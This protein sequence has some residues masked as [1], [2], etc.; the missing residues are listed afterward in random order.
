MATTSR[1][2]LREWFA[3]KAK[4]SAGQF[5][6]LFDS[7]WHKSDDAL[8]ISNISELANV[9]AGKVSSEQLEAIADKLGDLEALDTQNTSNLVA[10]INEVLANAGTSTYKRSSP[11]TRQVGGI[12]IGDV[13]TGKALDEL[14]EKML[15]PYTAPTL[16]N[17]TLTGQSAYNALNI[18]KAVT[19]RWVK[20]VGT[21]DFVSAQIQYRRTGET[22]WTDLATTV[23]HV[24]PTTEDA[25]A[26][27]TVN[28]GG[29]NNLG[30]EFRC[31]W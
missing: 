5:S 29:V 21:P 1:N 3:S 11:A 8:S 14:H 17:T 15:A 27:I 22:D 20:N 4:P 30:V 25:S 31:L 12:K 16:S 6:S 7:F 28:T 18:N 23:N 13:L 19:F 9:L 2:T 10:A 26:S 24:N